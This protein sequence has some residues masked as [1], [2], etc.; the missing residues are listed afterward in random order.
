[1]RR[2]EKKYIFRKQECKGSENTIESTP[3]QAAKSGIDR[4]VVVNSGTHVALRVKR[5]T[6]KVWR[7]TYLFLVYTEANSTY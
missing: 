1:M 2:T 5:C 6:A 7:L 4:Q 3:S